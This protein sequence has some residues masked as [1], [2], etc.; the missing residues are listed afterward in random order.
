[1]E[2][3]LPVLVEIQPVDALTRKKIAKDM[4]DKKS[5]PNLFMTPEISS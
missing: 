1:M 5:E 2:K 4:R 3:F